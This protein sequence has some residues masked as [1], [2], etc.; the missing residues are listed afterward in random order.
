MNRE[1]V[2]DLFRDDFSNFL[3]GLACSVF[4]VSL[5][6]MISSRTNLVCDSFKLEEKIRLFYW[7]KFVKRFSSP[8]FGI[9]HIGDGNLGPNSYHL[10]WRGI[11]LNREMD[12]SQSCLNVYSILFKCYI[13]NPHE[14][15]VCSFSCY[16]SIIYPVSFSKFSPSLHWRNCE[17]FYIEG[18]IQRLHGNTINGVQCR[19]AFFTSKH[20]NFASL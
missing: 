10:N 1:S 9:F 18:S 12:R 3:V 16:H 19:C 5:E 11:A 13:S 6:L 2:N 7:M 17:Y 8:W 14:C 20:V 15:M 4:V